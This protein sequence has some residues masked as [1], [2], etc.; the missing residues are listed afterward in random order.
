LGKN[1]KEAGLVKNAL[2]A[3]FRNRM[4]YTIK[5]LAEC[6]NAASE[7][8]LISKEAWPEFL[9]HGDVAGWR[10]LFDVFADFQILFF[11]QENTLAAVGHTVP[12]TWDGSNQDLPEN[13]SAIIQ[14]ALR[15][16]REGVTCNGLTALA[17][18]VRKQYR[19]IGLSRKIIKAMIELGAYS[20]LGY[21]LAPLRPSLKS[22]YPLISFEHYVKWKRDDG[23]PFD[24][25][26]KVHLDMG[27]EVMKLMEKSLTVRGNVSEW[28]SWAGMKFPESG[29]Y[30][31]EGALQPIQI[32]VEKDEGIYEE[33]NIWICHKM[34][35]PQ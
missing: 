22:M 24:P 13:I 35:K 16:K 6:P 20:G 17:A 2:S 1:R 18:M 31:V 4:Q 27:A 32:D 26:L 28:E 9:L 29:R 3:D 19:G 33:P 23:M 30:I 11:D 12:I 21:L 14:R 25:W 7:I 10:S 34:S 5:T 15:N 8:D